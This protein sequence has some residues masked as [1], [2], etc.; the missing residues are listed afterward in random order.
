MR[1][2][3]GGVWSWTRLIGGTGTDSAAGVAVTSR[4]DI[5]VAG[6][7]SVSI[8]SVGSHDLFAA[9]WAGAGTVR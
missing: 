3:R 2:S 7:F 6:G 5:Y 1:L 8:A 9:T 4:D